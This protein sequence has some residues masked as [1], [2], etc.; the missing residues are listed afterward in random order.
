MEWR[1]TKLEHKARNETYIKSTEGFIPGEPMSLSGDFS[2]TEWVIRGEASWG[3]V[4]SKE[5]RFLWTVYVKGKKGSRPV[6]SGLTPY[7]DVAKASVEA[8]V[9]GIEKAYHLSGG[10]RE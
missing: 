10:L 5:D 7:E 6:T 9:N 1:I 4:I 2:P 3:R 8:I